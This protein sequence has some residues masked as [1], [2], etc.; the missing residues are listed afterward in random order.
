MMQLV[1]DQLPLQVVAL[2]V[3]RLSLVHHSEVDHSQ[4]Q[5]QPPISFRRSSCCWRFDKE[6]ARATGTCHVAPAPPTHDQMSGALGL[7]A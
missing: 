2:L 4:D 3:E 1:L 7:A 5:L 6:L